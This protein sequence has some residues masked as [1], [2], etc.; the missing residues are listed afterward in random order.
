MPNMKNIITLLLLTLPI[1]AFAQIKLAGKS[2]RT[3]TSESCSMTTTGGY[4]TYSYR[5][6]I[7]EKDTVTMIGYSK[8]SDKE[9]PEISKVKYTYR[10]IADCVVIDA[11]YNCT[12]FTY[13]ET[14]R[15]DAKY[16]SDIYYYIVPQN[17][18]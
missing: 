3:K 9:Q 5:E 14:L 8:D 7:F 11:P 17:N 13:G 2:Y 12:L 18:G 10:V 6:L 4:M 16:E 15:Y 1:M